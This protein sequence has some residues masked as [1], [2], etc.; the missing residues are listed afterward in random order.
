[1]SASLKRFVPLPLIVALALTP[2]LQAQNANGL[3]PAQVS[4]AQ[5]GGEQLSQAETSQ[6][7]APSGKPISTGNSTASAPATHTRMSSRTKVVIGVSAAAAAV[8]IGLIVHALTKHPTFTGT[9]T[10][11]PTA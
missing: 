3:A 7:N 11:R 1:M 9:T 6:I 10:P 4:T 5:P 8:A 2:A